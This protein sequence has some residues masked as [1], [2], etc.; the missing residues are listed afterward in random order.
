[1][2][3]HFNWSLTYVS[4]QGDTLIFAWLKV[5]IFLDAVSKN[6]H[7]DQVLTFTFDWG[8]CTSYPSL[9]PSQ[10]WDDVEL[11]VVVGSK[12]T[13]NMSKV[14]FWNLRNG[15]Y[16]MIGRIVVLFLYFPVTYLIILYHSFWCIFLFI[17][18]VFFSFTIWKLYCICQQFCWEFYIDLCYHVKFARFRSI[19]SRPSNAN[20]YCSM[21][22]N[23]F[24][25][26]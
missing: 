26:F 12:N 23:L 18:W 5:M 22:E 13:G 19:V 6:N 16:K 8:A 15:D 1:M 2:W 7:W 9:Q 4:L 17:T 24:F 20:I 3:L 11:L 10:Q 25:F 14:S 21:K